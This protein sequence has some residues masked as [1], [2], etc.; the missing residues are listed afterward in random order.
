MPTDG[1]VQSTDHALWQSTEEARD[2]RGIVIVKH[3][4]G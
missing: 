2:E 4:E 1:A 3:N